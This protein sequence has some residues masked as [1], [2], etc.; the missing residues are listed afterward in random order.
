MR[1]PHWPIKIF[2]LL[3]LT[4]DALCEMTFE[5]FVAKYNKVYANEQ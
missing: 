5:Q 3:L 2:L 4:L 1:C